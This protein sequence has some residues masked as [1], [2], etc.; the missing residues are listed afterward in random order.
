[1][2]L[3]Q[4]KKENEILNGR[5]KKAIEVFS[6]QKADIERLKN[7]RD[8]AKSKL[9]QMNNV[10]H[11]LEERLNQNADNDTK[12][13]E[14]LNEIEQL[15]SSL[16]NAHAKIEDVGLAHDRQVDDNKK[17][18]EKYTSLE[19]DYYDLKSD[20]EKL[21]TLNSNQDKV[22]S[23]LKE[24]NKDLENAIDNLNEKY[25]TTIAQYTAL[26]NNMV[27]MVKDRT[28]TLVKDV[29]KLNNPG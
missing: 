4:L 15:K 14:Q 22:I 11:D 28:A 16:E 3:E 8:E 17:L 6:T 18:Q 23:A 21:N 27:Q 5:L 1:M 12:F 10:V 9:E 24:K 29:E 20:L 25:E 26:T 7:E 2:E 13:F 19:G